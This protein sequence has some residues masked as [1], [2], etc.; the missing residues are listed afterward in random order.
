MAKKIG[1]NG[2]GRIGRMVFQAICD[3][4]LLGKT[5]DVVAVVDMST[6][7]DYFAYQMKYDS[8]QGKFKHA[9]TTEKS[10]PSKTENDVIVV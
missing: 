9:V 8:V 10:D 3:Q 5:L 6:D 1:I 2:F 4:G 7:A